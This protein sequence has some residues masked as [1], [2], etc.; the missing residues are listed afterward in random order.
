MW[1]LIVGLMVAISVRPADAQ[2][3]ARRREAADPTSAVR[4][5]TPTLEG[6]EQ[7]VYKTVGD[8]ELR[9]YVFRSAEQADKPR[10]AIVFFFGG[11]WR[12]GSPT[13]FA[14]H[15]RYLARRG[16]I[17]I[18]CDY[19]VAQR[20]G[21]VATA[22]VEDAKSAMRWVRSNAEMLGVDPN[23]IVAA[24]G[25]AGGHL[26]AC[27]ALI[28]EFDAATDD[29][30]VSPRPNALA[31]FNPALILAPVPGELEMDPAK[32]K[33]LEKRAGVAPERISP[34]HHLRAAL[35][36]TVIFHGEADTTVPFETARLFAQKARE[37]GSECILHAYPDA[38][39]GFFNAN[40]DSGQA[41]RQTIQQLDAFL[42]EH[43][44]LEPAG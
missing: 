24:G 23:R 22:C 29:L 8:T 7:H 15:C 43:G 19:R 44:F 9:A 2:E 38:T 42:V 27:T 14:P 10:P 4:Q 39:H 11:G 18:A 26:A 30:N 35:P 33:E 6:A 41:F 25:S 20:H 21:V 5:A 34:Y 31:L 16:M 37:L 28:R 3:A 12:S 36:P 13:Q 32:Y 1:N 17:A 40:R